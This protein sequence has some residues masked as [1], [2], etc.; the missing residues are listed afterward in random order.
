M[1]KKSITELSDLLHKKSISSLE[2]TNYF[3][4]RIKSFDNELNSFITVD[5]E[6]AKKQAIN[7]DSLI[8][9]K[10]N[11]FLTGIPI[12]H[13][14]LFS[15]KGM[16]TTCASKMLEKYIPPFDATVVSNLDNLGMVKLGKTNMDE[17]AM[18]SSNESSYFGPVKN[19]WDTS[20]VPGGSSGGSASAVAARLTPI[21][22]GSDTGGS[23]RQPASFCGLTGLKPTYGSVSR[24]GMIAYASSLD[25]GG[26]IGKSAEDCRILYDQ[27]K[28]YDRNDPTSNYKVIQKNSNPRLSKE[29]AKKI[30][31]GIPK[32]YFSKDLDKSISDSIFESIKQFEKIGFNFKDISLPNHNL[33][34]PA[35]YIIASAEASSNLSRYDGIKFGHRCSEPKNLEDLYLRTRKEGF[36]TE[37]KKRIMI[38][39]YALSSGYYDEYYMRA[40]KIRRIIRDNFTLALKQVD[41]IFAPTSPSIAFNIGEKTS[42]AT[43][44]YLSDIYTTPVNLSGFPAISIPIG[45]SN[46]LPI[47][48]QIIGNYFSEHNI[49][50]IANLF[51]KETDWHARIPE[52]FNHE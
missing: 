24:Y 46:N 52:K 13:K 37:V 42:N 7:A 43:E 17:F 29:D 36:G 51:Q 20:K 6:S 4:E 40:L 15:T 47:G 30:T 35:Y 44:M 34:I 39:A 16:L 1:Y 22:T 27:I 5:E 38:G 11:T 32:E 25:Q 28:G 10:N 21:A 18:G 48:M 23:I 14:D 19:P 8:A 49:L 33:A 2:M 45:F 9:K 31:I 3:I 50:D 12:A 41:Y 26:P